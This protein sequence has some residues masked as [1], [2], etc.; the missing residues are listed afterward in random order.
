MRNSVKQL[1]PNGR[2]Y[3]V[4][5]RQEVREFVR[6]WQVKDADS[7][8]FGVRESDKTKVDWP[9]WCE[10]SVQGKATCGE[11]FD[12]E[13]C[14]PYS[15]RGKCCWKTYGTNSFWVIIQGRDEI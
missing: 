14:M 2:E 4:R 9:V 11:H 10:C 6:A 7:L 13:Y 3:N 12:V 8:L 5:N 1:G 15:R